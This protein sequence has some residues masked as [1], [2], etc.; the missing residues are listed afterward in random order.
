MNDKTNKASFQAEAPE[1]FPLELLTRPLGARQEYFEQR[2]LISHPRLQEALEDI[3]QTI[4]PP[5]E[6]ASTRRPGTMV[7][8]VGPSRVGKT[9]LIH[10]LEERLLTR[11]KELMMS[12]P[13]F[14]PFASILAAGTGTNRFE[15]T[16]YY[17]AVLRALHDPFVDGKVARIR[18]RELREAMETALLERKPLAIIVDEAHHLA[19]AARGSRLQ[20]Q[21]NHLKHFENATGVSHILVGTYE[22]RPFRKA[23]AQLA[24]RSVDVHF[25]RYDAAID[26]DAQV[27][28]SVV[29]ALQRQLPVEKE[30]SLVDHWEFL[31]ARSIGCVGLLK[32]HLNR[33]LNLALTEQAKTVTLTHLRKTAMPEARVEA[34]LRNALESEAELTEADGADERL[35]TLL[36]LRGSRTTQPSKTNAD[37]PSPKKQDRPGKRSP[38]RDTTGQGSGEDLSSPNSGEERAG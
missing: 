26:A 34:A 38:G 1:S 12:D 32:M 37:E 2:C 10:L 35:L 18:A 22:M 20:S 5:G 3:T 30:P 19:E 21:L 28:Q 29:W 14:I 6:G 16:E 15:W 27:F 7:L 17:R 23:N 9:T 33:A 4:C 11:T 31:Y 13:S 24:C 25:S 8:V 36:G